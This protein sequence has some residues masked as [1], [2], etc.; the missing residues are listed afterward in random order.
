M[1]SNNIVG[2]QELLNEI[3]PKIDSMSKADWR[4]ICDALI[5]RSLEGLDE[6]RM[7]EMKEFKDKMMCFDPQELIDDD[8]SLA[9]KFP[10]ELDEAARA[11]REREKIISRN[12]LL[13]K[14][15]TFMVIGGITQLA[16]CHYRGTSIATVCVPHAALALHDLLTAL[17]KTMDLYFPPNPSPPK[18]QQ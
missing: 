9:S 11:A 5:E 6:E 8:D 17:P 16:R 7:K 10:N 15:G 13:S 4:I 1:P 12:S 2:I 3:E 14:L 18:P